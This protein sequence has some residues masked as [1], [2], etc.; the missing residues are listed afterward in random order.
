ML[1]Q[2]WVFLES[3]QVAAGLSFTAVITGLLLQ[4]RTVP[5]KILTLF[6][7][8][9]FVQVT[10]SSTD[11]TFTWV[12]KWLT[13]QPFA[14]RSNRLALRSHYN[15]SQ[16][17]HD[18]T[19]TLGYGAHLLFW[20]YR[21]LIVNLQV[22]K[23]TM[24]SD[25]VQEWLTIT[26]PFG[27][28]AVLR[29]IIATAYEEMSKKDTISVYLWR[30]GHWQTSLERSIRPFDTLTLKQG[31]LER[32]K[33]DLEWFAKAKDWYSVRGIP[34][35][36]GYLFSGPPGT[37]KTS[38]VLSIAGHFKRPIYII[39]LNGIK[40]DE[41][42]EAVSMA[43]NDAIILL[44]DIDCAS[45]SISREENGKKDIQSGVSKA[46]LLNVLDGINTPEGRIF[47]MTTNYPERLDAALIRPGRADVHIEFSLFGPEE[48][49]RMAARFY[50]ED[51][52]PVPG[53]VSPALMQSVFMCYPNDIKAARAALLKEVSRNL[54]NEPINLA[55]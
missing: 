4:L 40:D 52:E 37:G 32:I 27:N 35:R 24:R 17:K 16:Q 12:I 26:V 28:Q 42:S 21:P 54:R 18:W 15:V 2:V 36:R 45:A 5:A 8:L 14:K 41:L 55:A 51:F 34:Y 1:D 29:N 20:N 46:G 53:E 9:F 25:S 3:N 23:S 48:Q 44:E 6:K 10:I 11:S 22:D 50:D 33:Q 39:G 31:Q 30:Y 38:T 43:Q 7:R 13:N 49:K 47:I 19:L